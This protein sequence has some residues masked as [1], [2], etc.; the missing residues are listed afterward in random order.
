MKNIAV[1]GA[2]T[3]G[4]GIA[5][6]FAQSGY[7]VQLIDVNKTALTH[8]A[9]TISKNLDRMIQKEIIT[10]ALKKETLNNIT[11]FTDISEGVE[12]ASLVVEAATENEALKLEIF[13][14]LDVACPDD[15]ILATNT[16]SIS[17][18]KIAAATTRPGQVIG[19]H[20]MNPVPVMP[21]V[22]IINGY[23]TDKAVT[24]FIVQLAK[25][26]G[27]TA[28]RVNDYPGFI[29]NRILMPMINEAIEALQSGV[30]GV[31]EIDGIMKLG[32][33]HPMGPLELADFIGL[34]VC[35]SI[36]E[37]MHDGF[38]N[39]K[40]APNPLL[41]NM[42]RAGKLGKKTREG[43]YNYT[44]QKKAVVPAARFL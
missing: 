39:P 25:E 32:M 27:K 23:N 9:Q 29:A 19:M 12:Y 7:K 11:M 1:I 4:N 8:A 40:Y 30:S 5:H 20:F 26:I 15:T 35:M 44:D 22:E 42:V 36:L 17:I 41:V 37:V 21:L 3:M 38:K 6:T 2:G 43:F 18:T 24:D 31:L 14:T 34:D 33:A 10:E 16:S 28:I 13:K